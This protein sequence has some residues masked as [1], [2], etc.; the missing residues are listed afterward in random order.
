MRELR[1]WVERRLAEIERGRAELG[2]NEGGVPYLGERLALD[3]EPGRARVARRDGRL[4]VPAGEWR[5]AVER[6]YR[7]RAREEIAPRLD[8]ACAEAGTRWGTLSIRGQRTRWA[9][10]SPSGDMSFNWRLLM[11]PAPGARHGRV[12]RGLPPRDRR[13]LAAVLGAARAPLSRSPHPPALAAPVR[14]R[15]GALAQH[16]SQGVIG[17]LA[18]LLL[19]EAPPNAAGEGLRRAV[20]AQVDPRAQAPRT[21]QLPPHGD[22]LHGR[23]LAVAQVDGRPGARSASALASRAPARRSPAP[24]SRSADVRP[25]ARTARSACSAPRRE[26]TARAAS[27]SGP[28]RARARCPLR[29]RGA[30]PPVRRGSSRGSA[31]TRR[32]CPGGSRAGPRPAAAGSAPKKSW[33]RPGSRSSVI[34]LVGDASHDSQRGSTGLGERVALAPSP[35]VLALLGQQAGRGAG[36]RARCRAGRAGATRSCRSTPP[37]SA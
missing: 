34:S 10:C 4:L 37:P 11:A 7:R 2:L 30:R 33:S 5:P 14:P 29:A 8:S 15:A 28:T 22:L 31:R 19:D 36:A 17:R 32:A 16:P 20:P 1:P 21:R 12:A 35:A 25:W 26:A 6:W 24:A 23:E 3:A 13:P 27:R 9:S 18:V